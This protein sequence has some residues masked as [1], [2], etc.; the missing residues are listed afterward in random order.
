MGSSEYRESR[1]ARHQLRSL[2][3]ADA[4]SHPDD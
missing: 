4:L 1:V 2:A 3:A